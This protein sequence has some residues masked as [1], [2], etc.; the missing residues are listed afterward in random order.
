MVSLCPSTVQG[1]DPIGSKQ[2]AVRSTHPLGQVT[3]AAFW[4]FKNKLWAQPF[5]QRVPAAVGT[6]SM[7]PRCQAWVLHSKN[8][9]SEVQMYDVP[10][11]APGEPP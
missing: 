3:V 7:H 2:K 9:L 4:G 1:F 6:L 5:A 11:W 8:P 10:H